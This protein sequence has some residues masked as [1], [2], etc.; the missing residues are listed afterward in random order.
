MT[1]WIE[2]YKPR[3]A[4]MAA[5]SAAAGYLLATRRADPGVLAPL[6]G[7]FL[8]AAGGCALNQLQ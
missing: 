7:T 2:L 8:L 4:G 3:L 6:A 5:L 1:P